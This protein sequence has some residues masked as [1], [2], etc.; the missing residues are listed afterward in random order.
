MSNFNDALSSGAATAQSIVS[1]MVA[2][3]AAIV[4]GL[5]SGMYNAGQMAMQGLTNGLAAGGA[6][7]IAK[8]Q[9]IAAQV[10]NAISGAQG[11]QNGSPSKYFTESGVFA[12]QGLAN[13]FA[14][15]SKSVV[16]IAG[17]IAGGV[18][19]EMTDLTPAGGLRPL[20]ASGSGGASSMTVTYAPVF[21]LSGTASRDDMVQ[22]QRISQKE[23]ERMM[24][25][26]QRSAGRV[27]FA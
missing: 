26:Y 19:T 15:M 2:S 4:S 17:N 13:G 10:K 6:A 18:K 23:F 27:A 20:Q 16:G 22:A 21:N 11:F 25:E 7:A 24:K 8:A 1:G 3:I 14:R 9:E 12:M 5:G